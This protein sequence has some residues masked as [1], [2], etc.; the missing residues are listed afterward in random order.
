MIEE[1]TARLSVM[2]EPDLNLSIEPLETAHTIPHT[3]AAE[4][5]PV[6]NIPVAF[7]TRSRTKN[8]MSIESSPGPRRSVRIAKNQK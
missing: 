3:L 5:L 1:P 2:N 4:A 6:D 7:R 8:T